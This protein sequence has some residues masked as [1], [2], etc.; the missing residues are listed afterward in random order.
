MRE[1]P[2]SQIRGSD[3]NKRVSV[4]HEGTTLKGKLRDVRFYLHRPSMRYIGT[5]GA[6]YADLTIGAVSFECVPADTPICIEGED[7]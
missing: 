2:I 1:I 5:P 6:L 7:E 4:T 3:I